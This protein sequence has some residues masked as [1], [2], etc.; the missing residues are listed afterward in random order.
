M[1]S[2]DQSSLTNL[3]LIIVIIVIIF[4]VYWL[5]SGQALS[6]LNPFSGWDWEFD[7]P[8]LPTYP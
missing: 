3:L 2:D 5:M 7:W 1:A 6:D 4:L 8:E